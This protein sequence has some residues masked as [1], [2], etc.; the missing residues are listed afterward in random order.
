MITR[1]E[2]QH[3]VANLSTL[4]EEDV[5]LAI[6]VSE[7]L[8]NSAISEAMKI[9]RRQVSY[10]IGAVISKVGADRYKYLT[11]RLVLARAVWEADREGAI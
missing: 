8:T 6:L 3:L 9:N 11:P 5:E 2:L 1:K 4:N 7:G 10:K